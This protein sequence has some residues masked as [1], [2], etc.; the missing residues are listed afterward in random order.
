V[1]ALDRM[2]R[3]RVM[4]LVDLCAPGGQSPSSSGFP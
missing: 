4:R 3:R 1:H 2:N